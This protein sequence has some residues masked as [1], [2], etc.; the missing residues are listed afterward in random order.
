VI[1]VLTLGVVLCLT[2]LAL[3]LNVLGTADFTKRHVTTQPLCTLAPGFAAS[4]RGF[5]T[6]AGL[7]LAVG[8]VALGVGMTSVYVPAGALL[9]VAGAVTFGVT[10]VIAITGEVETYRALK[11]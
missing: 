1:A 3:M 6:Y 11:R 5:R 2:G 4:D 10:S 7:V 8:T 9:V